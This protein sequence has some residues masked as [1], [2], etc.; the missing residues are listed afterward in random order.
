MQSAIQ[1]NTDTRN[2][3]EGRFNSNA[4]TAIEKFWNQYG[5]F[6]QSELNPN[7]NSENGFIRD[8]SKRATKPRLE[9]YY[10]RQE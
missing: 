3:T 8:A 10:S 4:I 9:Q 7:T 1:V 2:I 6:L 5:D